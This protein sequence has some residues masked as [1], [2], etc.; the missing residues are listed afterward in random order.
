M[1][2]LH[3]IYRKPYV[4]VS[5]LYQWIQENSSSSLI[6]QHDADDEI[7]TTHCHVCV[8]DLRVSLEALRKQINKRDLGGRG[9]Y[10]TL[11]STQKTKKSYDE[12]KLNEYILKG[13]RSNLRATTHSE[14]Y[15][16]QRLSAW[17][18]HPPTETVCL[19]DKEDDSVE[20]QKATKTHWQIMEEVIKETEKIPGLR[21]TT[22]ASQTDVF[23]CQV[24]LHNQWTIQGR[25]VLWKNMIYALEKYKVRTSRNELER[26]YITMLR[27]DPIVSQAIKNNIL[28]NIFRKSWQ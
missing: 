27:S 26:F 3:L 5:G 14:E 20:S 11:T 9:Q 4:D 21:D 24:G 13:D 18:N 1:L 28:E 25:D 16:V 7:K 23:G 19:L 17:V 10:Q 6:G 2:V 15:L 8:V 22:V 12:E